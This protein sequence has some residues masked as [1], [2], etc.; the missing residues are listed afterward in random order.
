MRWIAKRGCNAEWEAQ[1]QAVADRIA[2]HAVEIKEIEDRL[3]RIRKIGGLRTQ[4]FDVVPATFES[5][6]YLDLMHM[7]EHS[8]FALRC[9]GCG[10]PIPYDNSGRATRQRARAKKMQPIYHPECFAE[11]GRTRKKIYW[12]RRSQSAEF[13]E[14]ERQRVGAYRKS[15]C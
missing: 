6:L 3:I 5:A 14:R 9:S 10:L 12:Q 8:N 1:R 2:E 4:R 15:S 11:Y 7:L 13:R